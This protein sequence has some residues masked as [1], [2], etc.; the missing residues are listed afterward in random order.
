VL[1]EA[2]RTVLRGD[3]SI[4]ARNPRGNRPLRRRPQRSGERYE[5]VGGRSYLPRDLAEFTGR[6]DELRALSGFADDG[7]AGAPTLVVVD[8]MGGVGKTTLAVHV[9]QPAGRR[10]GD[11]QYFVDLADS[12]APSR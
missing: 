7:N 12:P 6:A 2:H 4:T 9:A 3:V 1:V 11:G 5:P 10:F 8:G